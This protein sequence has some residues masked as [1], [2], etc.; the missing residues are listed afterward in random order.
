[1]AIQNAGSGTRPVTQSFLEAPPNCAL[2]LAI[3]ESL[4]I[5]ITQ[6]KYI[7]VLSSSEKQMT[8]PA[9]RTTDGSWSN[10]AGRNLE[11]RAKRSGD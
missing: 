1:V 3:E 6:D 10:S 7:D 2:C 11:R 4:G 9:K 8:D 5:A